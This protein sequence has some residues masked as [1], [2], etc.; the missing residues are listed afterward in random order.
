MGFTVLQ[1]L[2]HNKNESPPHLHRCFDPWSE[3][4]GGEVDDDDLE[5]GTHPSSRL[6]NRGASSLHPIGEATSTS[7][8]VALTLDL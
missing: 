7:I 4:G 2:R 6:A 5:L 3:L 8:T 1:F